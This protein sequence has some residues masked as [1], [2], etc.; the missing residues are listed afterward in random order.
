MNNLEFKRQSFH[1]LFGI[2]IVILLM[3]GLIDKWILLYSA[4]IGIIISFLSTRIKIPVISWFLQNFERSEDMEKFPGKGAI[5]YLIGAFLAALFFPMDIAMPSILIL[6]F[7]DSVSRLFG[8]HYGKRKHLLNGDKFIEGSVA[9]FIAAFIGALI[10]LPWHE[11][12]FASLVAMVVESIELKLGRTQI[13]DNVV[14]PLVAGIAIW[15]VRL[16]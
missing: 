4:I 13:D 3:Y 2:F 1:F 9:G 16:F 11:A 7:G 6:A 15:V 5:S 14:I 12:L 10:F 8:I